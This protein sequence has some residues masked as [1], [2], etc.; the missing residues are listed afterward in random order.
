MLNDRML[1]KVA[2]NLSIHY[3]PSQPF[4]KTAIVELDMPKI[5]NQL[6]QLFK[7]TDIDNISLKAKE[8]T[9]RAKPFHSATEINGFNSC[10]TTWNIDSIEHDTKGIL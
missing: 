3:D 6:G 1:E 10:M 4:G 8:I 5:A 2:K 9:F 7:D